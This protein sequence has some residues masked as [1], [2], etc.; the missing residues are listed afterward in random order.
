MNETLP[1]LLRAGE[2]PARQAIHRFEFRRPA[3]DARLDVPLEGADARDL[4]CQHH[5]LFVLAKFL[6][7]EFAFGDVDDR[8]EHEDAF[9]GAYGIEADFNWHFAAVLA[10]AEQIAARAH[11]ARLRA[12]EEAAA[13]SGVRAAVTFRH[14]HF[15]GLA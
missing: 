1:R 13:Q 4:L 8:R 15:H 3:V 5:A 12:L 14:E 7:G 2:A 10:L 9:G 6:L 11:R